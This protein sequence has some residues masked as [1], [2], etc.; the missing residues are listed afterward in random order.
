MAAIIANP[1]EDTPRLAFADWLEEHG[2][3][4]DRARA[5]F[6]RSQVRSAALP[7]G[8]RERARMEK[9]ATRL[10]QAR[11]RR[12]LGRLF[13][14]AGDGGLPLFFHRGLLGY[15]HTTTSEFLKK[16]YQQAVCEWFPR[17]GVETLR[18]HGATKRVPL[19]A[20][21]PA[22][23]WVVA[24]D[25]SDSRLDDAGCA[26]LAASPH[27]FRLSRLEIHR[28]TC[29][30]AGL[31]ALADSKGFANL[32]AL[33]LTDGLWAGRFTHKGLLRILNSKRLPKLDELDLS[34]G[35]EI[36]IGRDRV[37]WDRFFA[38]RGL[39]RLHV[40]RVGW[41]VDLESVIAC[42]RLT[43]LEELH[44]SEENMLDHEA[45]VLAE[46]PALPR[47]RKV[48]LADMN[49]N[50]PRLGLQAEKALRDRFG[51]GLHLTYRT[52]GE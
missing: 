5:E 48:V 16:A 34:K 4:H 24:F 35:Q 13:D 46:N 32:R 11:A 6:I 26:A 9:A 10:F 1:D 22:L 15:W 41:G 3:E 25:W 40:L 52:P 8:D 21:S 43:N 39:S 20:A 27:T 44:I 2:D 12:W 30:D 37:G 14:F 7:D 49:P 51:T 36:L 31:E 45:L 38:N 28:P 23:E 33:A 17:L 19:L 29:T 47:V 50:A 18:L 42:Q